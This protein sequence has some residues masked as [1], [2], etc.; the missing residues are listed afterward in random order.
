MK[1]IFEYNGFESA[2]DL[3]RDMSELFDYEPFN[4]LDGE[5]KG[6]LKVTVEYIKS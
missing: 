4:K 3:F 1:K 5:F 2:Y 6:T